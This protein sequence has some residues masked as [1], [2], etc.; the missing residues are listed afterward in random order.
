MA[1][2]ASFALR[3]SWW[4]FSAAKSSEFFLPAK[5]GQF[6]NGVVILCPHDFY[7]YTVEIIERDRVGLDQ[8][9]SSL[10][11]ASPPAHFSALEACRHGRGI[12]ND[13]RH[14]RE[15]GGHGTN[16]PCCRH[17][18]QRHA[19]AAGERPLLDLDL[20]AGAVVPRRLDAGELQT[21]DKLLAGEP[22]GFEIG[23][24]VFCRAGAF[25]PPAVLDWRPMGV[26]EQVHPGNIKALR[27]H[28]YRAASNTDG[29]SRGL[30]PSPAGWASGG[31]RRGPPDAL[32]V[33]RFLMLRVAD[34]YAMWG[35]P[36]MLRRL[37]LKVTVHLRVDRCH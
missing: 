25:A 24:A 1:R 6:V 11:T 36:Q 10:R 16:W 2:F 9:A 27:N 32:T 31:H 14:S 20:H 34:V 19:A 18:W 13:H 29:P 8:L 30:R 17:G 21:A 12:T 26:S 4:G 37:G 35:A 22:V 5:V 3:R 15:P 33:S 28:L 7:A 23:R